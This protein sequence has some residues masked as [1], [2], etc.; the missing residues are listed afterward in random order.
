MPLR[1]AFH[2]LGCKL[3]QLE[4]ESVADAFARAGAFVLAL[5]DG[6]SGEEDGGPEAGVS[7]AADIVVINTCT[8]TGKAEQKARRIV[9]LALAA[10]PRAVVIVTGCYAEVEAA[11]ITAL[12]D[13]VIVVPGSSKD[14]LLGLPSRIAMREPGGDLLVELRDRLA[15]E[16]AARR[17]G[18]AACVDGRFAFNPASFAFHS[19]PSLK[20]QDGCDNECAY[21]R[22]HIAR[23]GSTSLPSAHAVSRARALEEA[24]RAEI[25]LAGVNLSQYRD[26]D[27]DFPGLLR[28]LV[29]GTQRVA[30]RISSYEPDRID[31][32]FLESFAEPRIRPHVHFALQSGSDPV[33]AAMGRHYGRDDILASVEALRRVRRDP[34]IGADM[35]SGFPGESEA[36]AASS[37]ELARACRFAWI[38]AFRFSPRPGTK[39]ASMPGRVPERVAGERVA[40]LRELA[41]TGKAD[42]IE[43]WKGRELPAVLEGDSCATTDNYLRVKLLGLPEGVGPGTEIRCRIETLGRAKLAGEA[44]AEALYTGTVF[45]KA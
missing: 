32:R 38:H 42:Y 31:E 10:D 45:G 34:F 5:G 44:D 18:A 12:G 4:T 40:A 21:C 28:L 16:G 36:D 39:A 1:V 26:G 6:P 33:L 2:T 19:R 30:F 11:A 41:R 14:E 29:S 24:G 27:T 23:G 25:V 8:V 20:I 3:N 22:V 43:R 15:A 9:R 37:L 13:R 7:S 35:I 17:A